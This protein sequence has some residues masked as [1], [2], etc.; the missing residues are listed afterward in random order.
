MS[1]MWFYL[2]EAILSVLRCSKKNQN[3]IGVIPIR[4][5]KICFWALFLLVFFTSKLA[6]GERYCNGTLVGRTAVMGTVGN[7]VWPDL[8]ASDLTTP[9]AIECQR[10]IGL[11]NGFGR[12]GCKS[13]IEKVLTIF[14]FGHR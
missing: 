14:A 9:D 11:G 8:S 1:P 6:S 10:L 5:Q 3:G 4:E 2:I 13:Q 7:G 12:W